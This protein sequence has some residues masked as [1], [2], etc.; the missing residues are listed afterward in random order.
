M[1][2]LICSNS[3]HCLVITSC[4]RDT[5]QDRNFLPQSVCCYFRT[6]KFSRCVI[7][8]FLENSHDWWTLG[9]KRNN[10]WSLIGLPVGRSSIG[11]KWVFKVKENPNGFLHKYKA[12]LV[13]KGFH[14]QLGF[15]FTKT[16]SLVVKPITIRIMLIIVLTQ[17]SIVRQLDVNNTFL[18]GVLQEKVYTQ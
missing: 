16:F 8:W 15:D 1:T 5:F 14:Q 12:R 10:T 17:G 18:N 11:C 2:S 4:Y 3:P 6:Y 7:E 13:A 9:P